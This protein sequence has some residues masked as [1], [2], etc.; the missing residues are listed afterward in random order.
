MLTQ[1]RQIPREYPYY[2]TDVPGQLAGRGLIVAAGRAT[3]VDGI[4]N[5]E[6]VDDV[7]A[8]TSVIVVSSMSEG[9]TGNLRAV[10]IVDGTGFDIASTNQGDNGVVGWFM[11]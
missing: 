7:V 1:Y 6:G 5:I 9:V 2:G 8:A 11:I 3:L 10:N 4:V